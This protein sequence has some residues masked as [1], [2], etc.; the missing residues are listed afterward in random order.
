MKI[1]LVYP[2][3][4]DT[5]WSFKYALRF[6]RKR[7]AFPPLGLITVA[8]MLPADWQAR[9]VDLNV[10]PLTDDDLNWADYV[11]ISAMAV[12]RTSAER[13]IARCSSAGKKI[14]AG[15]PLFTVDHEAFAAVDHFVLNEAEITLPLFL[16]DL[17]QGRLKRLYASSEFSDMEQA[18]I[19]RWDLLDME[20]YASMSVQWSRGCPFQCEF[21]DVTRLFGHSP[22]VKTARQVIA[23]LDQ[24][25]AAGWRGK[26]FFVDD[27]LI[28]DKKRLKA[29]LLPALIAWQKKVNYRAP[30]FTQVS[31]NL[32]QDNELVSLIVEAGFD[33]VFI[34]IETPNQA[35]LSD[36]RKTQNMGRNLATDVETLQRAGLLVMGGF[37]VGFDPDDPATIF[38]RQIVFVMRSGITMAMV[39]MLS[40]PYGT[41]L[42]QRLKL[43]NRLTGQMSGDNV[44]G[45]TNIVPL[46]GFK[47]LR[48]GYGFV[49]K[50]L[51]SPP[52]YYRRVRTFLREFPTP[53]VSQPINCQ[54]VLA[55]FR[56][57]WHLGLAESGGRRQ[58]WALLAWVLFC[59][60]RLFPLAVES[61][62]NGY[63]FRKVTELH[64]K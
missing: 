13:L 9:L 51:Y 26:V 56:A 11:F 47:V 44:D 39:G 63:H 43:A 3:Y 6:I 31:I 8:A 33:S 23:E 16:A 45:S 52:N 59:R 61:A 58:F 18:A 55:F 5:F 29:E 20:A 54:R 12:Q 34:G 46:M 38:N 28:G 2:E 7:A 57:C 36:C 1:L 50:Y 42:W 15:G 22:R 37:I 24:L 21:C 17:A 14:V 10:E 4:P 27:N 64:I 19:P 49:M 48:D 25:W 62:I 41:K 30:F 40:A 53:K 60:P 35:A 32:A